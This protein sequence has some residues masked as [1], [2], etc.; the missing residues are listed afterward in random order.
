MLRKISTNVNDCML[1]SNQVFEGSIT[2]G[3]T[4]NPFISSKDYLYGTFWTVGE[5]M[6]MTLF[7]H[8]CEIR[9]NPDWCVLD[10]NGHILYTI[11]AKNLPINREKYDIILPSSGLITFEPIQFP[12]FYK[13]WT[14]TFM[15]NIDK[16]EFYV[17]VGKELTPENYIDDM[18]TGFATS[19][20]SITPL[21]LKKN[22]KINT[23]KIINI[24]K[25]R[26]NY[27]KITN[28]DSNYMSYPL[29]NKNNLRREVA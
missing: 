15:L 3:Y 9:Y 16:G 14:R 13:P 24:N 17:T 2:G 18:H 4:L 20:V 8:E 29:I 12:Y 26:G 25:F 23:P 28:I 1:F 27:S 22:F 7:I 10:E 5:V 19:V 21:R 11:L 6:Y